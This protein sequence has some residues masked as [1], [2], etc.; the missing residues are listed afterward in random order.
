VLDTI[1][2][3]NG[4]EYLFVIAVGL[5]SKIRSSAGAVATCSRLYRAITRAHMMVIVVDR[6]AKGG[7]LEFLGHIS[8]DDDF[9]AEQ[10]ALRCSNQASD[11]HQ[12]AMQR[13]TEQNP[14]VADNS[15][16]SRDFE[17]EGGCVEE[18]NSARASANS[19]RM[20]SQGI[21]DITDNGA[22]NATHTR[23]A[24]SFMPFLRDYEP[25]E[26]YYE[27]PETQ[28]DP[29][30]FDYSMMCPITHAVMQ[31]PVMSVSGYTYE[32]TAVLHY[33]ATKGTPAPDPMTKDSF[34]ESDL[35]PNRALKDAIAKRREAVRQQQAKRPKRKQDL[36]NCTK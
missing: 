13:Q 11:L 25:P 30:D 34:T 9:S 12:Q 22:P 8:F 24:P 23:I 4:M 5:D 17:D 33:L 2:E 19:T 28:D 36:N 1:D 6:M 18:D 20:I 14:T 31:D 7:W 21:W 10:E 15:C 35:R 3:F 27:P 29:A 16:E 32:K 26:T